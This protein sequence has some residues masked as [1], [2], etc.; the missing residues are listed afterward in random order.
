MKIAILTAVLGNFDKIVDP[1]LQDVPEGVEYTFHRFTDED[2]PPI[3]D[4]PPRFQYRIPKLYGWQMFPGYDVYIWLDGTFSFGRPDCLEWFLEKLGDAD[5]AFFKHPWRNSAAEETAHIEEHLAK[6]TPYIA[7]RY[8]NGLHKEQLFQIQADPDYV[9]D[10]LY[11]ST[12]FIYRDN[13]S[14]RFSLQVWWLHSS[15][16]F[17]VDQIVQPYAV[18]HL[19]VNV[20]PDNQY[21]TPYLTIVST[22]K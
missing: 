18:R 9:D 20:I 15:R 13:P 14:V 19:K 4:L 5:M 21:K 11:T 6:K 22:H 7:S 8:K 3:A 16:Y 10:K 1:V 2:F 17:T 12:A